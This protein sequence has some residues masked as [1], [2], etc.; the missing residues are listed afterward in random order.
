MLL[1]RMAVLAR[2]GKGPMRHARRVRGWL[3]EVRLP[4]IRP[5]WALVAL[6][7]E[8]IAG[9]GHAALRLIYRE[10]V[11]RSRCARVGRRLILEGQIPEIIG[12]GRVEVG[13]DVRVGT[14][15]TW[16]VGLKVSTDP[17]LIIGDRTSVN[18]Q[19]TISVAKSVRIGRDVMIAGNAQ[20]YDN[21]SHP[22]SARRRQ[23]HDSIT[24][25]EATPVVI[26]D[27]AWIGAGAIIIR[28]SVGANSIVAAGA[29]V[30]KDVPANTVVG[31]NPA[32]IIREITD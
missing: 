14:R 8:L 17:E 28:A 26:G 31:G 16:I 13:D 24:L 6:L 25:G 4:V 7:T 3:L 21:I 11:F 2:Q 23:A 27:N 12:G 10:P 1:E 9:A 32:R 30:T 15:N 18:Y 5:F 19:T 29:V 22:V 20:I